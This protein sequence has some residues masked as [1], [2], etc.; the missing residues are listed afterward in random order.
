M[1]KLNAKLLIEIRITEP[2]DTKNV[3]NVTNLKIGQLVFVKDHHKGT[4]DPTYIFDHRVAGI[5]ND[6]TVLPTTLDG[7]EKR[8]SIHYIKPVTA[9]EVSA[10]AFQPFQDGI[11]KDQ[12]SAQTGHSYNLCSKAVKQ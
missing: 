4:F 2:K 7:K 5:I 3:T 9:L 6:S 1:W 8:C 11:Q 10:S 12:S